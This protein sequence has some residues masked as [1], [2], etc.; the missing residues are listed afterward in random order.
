MLCL[1]QTKMNNKQAKQRTQNKTKENVSTHYT[2]T[3]AWLQKLDINKEQKT[4]KTKNAHT[5]KQ[6]KWTANI[7]NIEWAEEK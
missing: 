6:I 5:R 4:L 3:M 1:E 2:Y 7:A